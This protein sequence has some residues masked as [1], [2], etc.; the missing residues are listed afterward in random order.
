MLRVPCLCTVRSHVRYPTQLQLSKVNQGAK[1]VKRDRIWANEQ[2]APYC[3][4][5][6]LSCLSALH[7]LAR[8]L[9]DVLL[10]HEVSIRAFFW[11]SF[12]RSTPLQQSLSQQPA[13]CRQ[14]PC[15]FEL[16]LNPG[17]HQCVEALDL[18]YMVKKNISVINTSQNLG[19]MPMLSQPD[20][21][22]MCL[23]FGAQCKT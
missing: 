2:K 12:G 4:N 5:S 6:V 15:A 22:L 14:G 1:W 23:T 11:E 18:A 13:R 20:R 7:F 19:H 21:P 10:A 9:H 16:T 8:W 3:L 17:T